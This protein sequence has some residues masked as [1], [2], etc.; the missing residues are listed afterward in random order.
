MRKI[1]IF[2]FLA[3]MAITSVAQPVPVEAPFHI[4]LLPGYQLTAG[5]SLDSISGEIRKHG[6]LII[7]FDLVEAYT[8]CKSC[9]WTDGELW[10]KKQLV[11][12]EEAVFVFTKSKRLV[13]S[14][15]KSHANFYA[16]IRNE[17]DMADMLLMLSTFEV[18][19]DSSSK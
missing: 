5:R 15:P 12:E 16:T 18:L 10:R 9:G 17:S 2:V 11:N 6:G 4:R 1:I 19:K 3:V 13:V 8:D 14:F 7:N